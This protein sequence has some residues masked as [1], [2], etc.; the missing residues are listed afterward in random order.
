MSNSTTIPIP[1]VEIPKALPPEESFPLWMNEDLAKSGM[2]PARAAALGFRPVTPDQYPE[3]LGITGNGHADGYLIPLR[4][5]ETGEQMQTPDGRPFVRVKLRTAGTWTDPVTGRPASMKYLS[6]KDGGQHAYILPE[7]HRA[8]TTTAMAVILTE[9]EKKSIKGTEAGV[10]MIGLVGNYG[11]LGADGDLL[12]ELRRYAE[13]KKDW[14]VVWDSD[15]ENNEKFT[16]ATQRLADLLARYGCKLHV[17]ILPVLEGLDKV[18]VDDYIL[19]PAGGIKQL[20]E[21]ILAKATEVS[22][23]WPDLEQ[24]PVY[25]PLPPFPMGALPPVLGD[26]VNEIVRSDQ[27]APEAAALLTLSVTGFAASKHYRATIKPGVFSRANLYAVIFQPV[28][29]RKSTI[30][31]RVLAAVEGWITLRKPEWDVAVEQFAIHE[32]RVAALQKRLA[33]VDLPADELGA[34]RAQLQHERE[35]LPATRSP[36]LLA[37]DSTTEAMVVAMSKT[38]GVLGVFSD[39]A[40]QFLGIL[41]G[42][43]ADGQC[44]EAIF[45]KGY[46]GTAPIRSDRRSRQTLEIEDPCIGMGL[47]VQLDWLRKLGNQRDLEQSGFLSRNLFCVPDAMTGTRDEQGNLRRAFSDY[48]VDPVVSQKYGALIHRLLDHAH[49][50]ET[51]TEIPIDADARGLWVEFYNGIE[52]ELGKGR[53]LHHIAELAKRY[54]SQA[55]RLALI[56]TL[57]RAGASVSVDDMRNGIML[58]SYYAEH[59][60]RAFQAMR[61]KVLPPAPDRIVKYLRRNRLTAFTLVELQRNVGDLTHDD[62]ADAVRWMVE[63]GY[64]RPLAEKHDGPGRKPS[65][66]Y[67]VNPNLN[68]GGKRP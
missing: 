52:G 38:G 30:Y 14:W 25:A 27:V 54:P 41:T 19:H 26:M 1:T 39:D 16:K 17:L 58:M 8:I 23:D 43:Y 49:A 42:R 6:P 18:G 55:L 32:A 35:Q 51:V 22:V 24:E 66:R 61:A 11:Y 46:D 37:D 5:P 60:E 31:T 13:T 4:Y 9:G 36:Y 62:V 10:P 67:I 34:V 12:P 53:S 28:A 3:L 33:D 47:M 50:A 2:T 20:G 45:L 64:C 68:T 48:Q 63:H 7:V 57:C 21:L 29:E 59:A 40:R 65:P 44:Q 15:A 56:G